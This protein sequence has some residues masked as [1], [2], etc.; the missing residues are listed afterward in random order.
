VSENQIKP[1]DIVRHTKDKSLVRGVVKEIA[2]SGLRAYVGWT[3]EDNPRLN[4]N[5]WA[6]Y[7]LDLLEKVDG[8]MSE[9]LS[10]KAV[11]EFI[12]T[13]KAKFA[14]SYKDIEYGAYLELETI[15]AHI[16]SGAFDV[17][18]EKEDDGHE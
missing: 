15:E 11:L 18:T 3:T 8:A 12:K 13:R 9:Y 7:R 4:W 5:V 2:K 14:G 10:K 1:G 6:Y 17:R 16:E